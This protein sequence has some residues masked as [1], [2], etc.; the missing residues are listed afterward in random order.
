[1]T[2]VTPLGLAIVSVVG[3]GL[4][5]AVLSG[6]AELVVVVIPMLL[7]LLRVLRAPSAPACALAHEVSATRVSE[8]D[9]VRV[10]VTVAAARPLPLVELFEPLPATARLAE[11]RNRALV[12]VGRAGHAEWTYEL[13]CA[14]RG[15]LGIGTVHARIWD[16]AG[17]RARELSLDARKLVRVYPRLLPV[18]RLPR[19][20]RTQTSV[21]NYVA[22][23]VG[24]GLEPGDIRPFVSGDRVRRVNW[25]ASLR[26]QQLYVTEYQQ[27][28]NADVVLMLDSLAEFGDPP[29]TTLDA[30][31]RAVASLTQAYLQ[32]KDRVGFIEYGGFFRSVRPGSGRRQYERVLDALFRADVTFSY[33]TRDLAL[34]PKRL[35]PPQA[36]VLAVSPLLEPRFEKAVIDLAARGFDVL[37]LSPSPVPLARRSAPASRAVD[38]A[39]RLWTIERRDRADALR[40]LG[41]A[42]VDW[43]PVEPLDVAL[44]GLGHHRR[45]RT[46]YA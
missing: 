22:T 31:I 21:G 17:L 23:R 1:M 34:V 2:R 6:R 40:R 19:P 35:L 16:R 27:E 12:A 45:Q 5:L 8:S 30:S 26:W 18:R 33:V 42:V 46:V 29:N 14:R 24:E 4:V 10:R 38:L 37:I 41:I 7:G 36:L 13:A 44:H 25:R 20:K 11:G 28:K 3:S 9:R 39:C 43:D 15:P 32:R